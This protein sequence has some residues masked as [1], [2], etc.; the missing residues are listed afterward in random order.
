MTKKKIVGRAPDEL[1][2]IRP[3]G[4]HGH[5]KPFLALTLPGK[6]MLMLGALGAAIGGGIQQAMQMVGGQGTGFISGEW[7]GVT[8]SRDCKCTAPSP[9]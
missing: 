2:G 8:A 4:D 9:C 6:G 3:D 7:R 1:E 5:S